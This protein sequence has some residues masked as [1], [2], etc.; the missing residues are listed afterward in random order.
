M[1]YKEFRHKARKSFREQLRLGDHI[2]QVNLSYP[3]GII[4]EK[5]LS[6]ANIT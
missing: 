1:T 3:I 6:Y 4:D 2:D 5:S